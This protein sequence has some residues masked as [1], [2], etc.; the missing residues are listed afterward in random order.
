MVSNT[1]KNYHPKKN[2]KNSVNFYFLS[3]T[4]SSASLAIVLLEN[5]AELLP[6]TLD[7]LLTGLPEYLLSLG[8]LEV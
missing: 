1:K 2:E 4:S 7:G 5:V 8:E 3:T 6:T